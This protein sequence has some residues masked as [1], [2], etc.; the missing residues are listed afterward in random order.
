MRAAPSDH[1]AA[2]AVVAAV[3]PRLAGPTRGLPI[4]APALPQL[5]VLLMHPSPRVGGPAACPRAVGGLGRVVHHRGAVVAVAAPRRLV[6]AA[7][8][9]VPLATLP[10]VLVL[11]LAPPTPVLLMHPLPRVS[12]PAACPRAVGGLGRVVV[13]FH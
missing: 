2:D 5:W 7:A 10:P 9:A 4:V 13:F 11:V 1:G 12:G 3:V 6:V 8:V